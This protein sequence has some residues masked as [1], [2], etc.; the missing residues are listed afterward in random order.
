VSITAVGSIAYDR[1]STPYDRDV[2]NLG[3]SATYF[4]LAASFFSRV[5]LVGVIGEDFRS[6]DRNL[7]Q[8]RDIDLEGLQTQKGAT[9]FY[10]GEYTKDWNTRLTHDTQLNVFADFD[11]ILPD[12]YLENPFLFLGN[13]QPSLQQRVMDQFERKAKSPF[14]ILDTMNLW[15]DSAQEDLRRLLKRVDLLMIN[16]SE[17]MQLTSEH[18]LVDI[19]LALKACG[20]RWICLKKGEHGCLLTDGQSFFLAP[21]DPTIFVVD[22]TGAGDAFAG[23]LTG[24]L[25]KYA[26]QHLS[27]HHLKQAVI[28]GSIMGGLTV[29]AFGVQALAELTDA[30]F[31]RK[32][33]FFHTITSFPSEPSH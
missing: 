29:N 9:F 21:A 3:G 20:P 33:Q 6:E 23:G 26:S 28:C 5:H 1:I 24:F 17:A 15:I 2:I 12:H 7:L 8:Q 30:S 10:H 4:S 13:I 19:L 14:V 25:A 22:P 31:S 11:P 16:D 27:W 32:W 18:R